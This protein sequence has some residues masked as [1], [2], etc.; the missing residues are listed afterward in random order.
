MGKG[1]AKPDDQRHNDAFDRYPNPFPESRQ[2]RK[3]LRWDWR[4]VDDG[5]LVLYWSHACFAF[6]VVCIAWWLSVAKRKYNARG[7]QVVQKHS[8]GKFRRS[9]SLSELQEG[10]CCPKNPLFEPG[11]MDWFDKSCSKKSESQ[12]AVQSYKRGE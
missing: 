12:A 9:S 7:K 3:T 10:R 6:Y 2:Q 1:M 8:D 5:R 11:Y 4:G